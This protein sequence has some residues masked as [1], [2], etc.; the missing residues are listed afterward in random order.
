M[1]GQQFDALKSELGKANDFT[2]IN[3]LLKVGNVP[4]EIA[5]SALKEIPEY[6]KSLDTI[7]KS[8]STS[9]DATTNLGIALNGLKSVED[10]GG[11]LS[12]GFTGLLSTIPPIVPAALALG[13]AL[14]VLYGLTKYANQFNDAVA[15]TSESQSSYNET[16]SELNN[17]NSQLST[18]AQ[19]ISE[20]QA[21]KN[22]GAISVTEQRELETLKLQNQ[23]LERQRDLK[24]QEADEQSE[25]TVNDALAALK[26]KR[27]K[28]LSL[29]IRLFSISP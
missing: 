27:T 17:L 22:M 26:L 10:T 24:Q 2:E 15:K 13:G 7:A 3:K 8:A 6:A 29:L 12:S 23:E 28:D 21:L 16:A 4:K 25:A 5:N 14:T 1:S 18:S 11:K 20:L 19:H 9:A